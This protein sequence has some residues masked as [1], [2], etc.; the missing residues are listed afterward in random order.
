MCYQHSPD[1][2]VHMCATKTHRT[3]VC[4]YVLLTIIGQRYAFVCYQHSPD[5]GVYMCA[6][7]THRTPVCMSSNRCTQTL[8]LQTAVYLFSKTRTCRGR[9]YCALMQNSPEKA[10]IPATRTDNLIPKLYILHRTAISTLG[11]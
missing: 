2:G 7:N 3:A 5:S 8:S 1:S 10:S 6:T 4:I 9:S 11:N